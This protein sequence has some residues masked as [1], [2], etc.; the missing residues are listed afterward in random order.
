MKTEAVNEAINAAAFTLPGIPKCET[1][2]ALRLFVSL[3]QNKSGFLE[4]LVLGW[5]KGKIDDYLKENCYAEV[6]QPV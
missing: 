6:Q 2:I 1:A 4:K 3:L 5:L